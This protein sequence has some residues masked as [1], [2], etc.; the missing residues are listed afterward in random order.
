MKKSKKMT[1]G[2]GLHITQEETRE[3]KYQNLDTNSKL[4]EDTRQMFSPI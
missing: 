4:P 3:E 2:L 1:T